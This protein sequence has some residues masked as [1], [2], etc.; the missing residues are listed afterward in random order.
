MTEFS[1]DHGPKN[2][3]HVG[4][5]DAEGKPLPTWNRSRTKRKK[6]APVDEEDA[7]Q[8]GMREG[9][10]AAKGRWKTLSLAGFAVMVVVGGG[11]FAI[12]ESNEAAAEKTRMLSKTSA[13]IG[14]GI[15]VDEDQ[16]PADLSRT[17]PNPLFTSEEAKQ[18]AYENYLADLEG[19][20]DAPALANLLRAAEQLRLG[21]SESAI[22]KYDAFIAEAGEAH[23]LFFLALEGKG[24]ALENS[25]KLEEALAVFETL[26]GRKGSFFRDMALW[27]QGRTLESLGREDDARGVY[28][29]Y[30]EEFPPEVS[31][32]AR[33]QV[34]GRLETLD[35][36]ALD[37]PPAPGLKPPSEEP[38]E[39]A[40]AEMAP[41]GG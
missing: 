27:H 20:A 17:T 15:V 25:G 36:T 28:R 38:A 37:S 22:A 6:G 34:R 8:R 35:P 14:R 11:M 24:I 41:A 5:A 31:S 10:K 21:E 4:D 19:G 33:E 26:A 9:S 16:L 1:G 30:V 12:S 32:L 18:E 23:P 40:G 2:A 7:F 13:V 3:S 39:G 29:T